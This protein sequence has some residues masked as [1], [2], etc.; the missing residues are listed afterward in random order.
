MANIPVSDMTA[1]EAPSKQVDRIF[2][3][4][5]KKNKKALDLLSKM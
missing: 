4:L 2:E 1:H 3:R 5:M